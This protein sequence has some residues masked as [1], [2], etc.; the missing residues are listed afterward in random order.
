[1]QTPWKLSDRLQHIEAETKWQPI[2]WRYFQ[3]H[4]LEWKYTNFSIKISLKFVPNGLIDIIPALVQIMAWCQPGH[5][6]LSEPMMVNSL[7]HVYSTQPQWVNSLTPGRCSGSS[8]KCTFQTYF[9]VWY[10]QHFL[11]NCSHCSQVN[12]FCLR[13]P[14]MISQ[15]RFR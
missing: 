8:W 7:T 6:L 5:K 12:A 9:P 15:H 2:S 1:M 4:F 14:L 13:T 10:L 11:W 3:M